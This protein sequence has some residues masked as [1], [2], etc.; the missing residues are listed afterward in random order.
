MLKQESHTKDGNITSKAGESVEGWGEED[1]QWDN[2]GI[3][4]REGFLLR[5]LSHM[6]GKLI[7]F[8]RWSNEWHTYVKCPFCPPARI[9]WATC[10]QVTSGSGYAPWRGNINHQKT[11]RAQH[12]AQPP[13]VSLPLSEV[14][15]FACAEAHC[16]PP[17]QCWD[18]GL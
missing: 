7:W 10:E 1:Q 9:K 18:W 16:P 5:T 12:L 6:S 13:E 15:V 3:V 14:V 2:T 11:Q 17:L 8:Q 4:V